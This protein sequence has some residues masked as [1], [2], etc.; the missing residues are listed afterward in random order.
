MAHLHRAASDSVE[1]LGRADDLAGREGLDDELAV[2]SL[3]HQPG[4]RLASA[5]Q[6]IE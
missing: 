1:R 3:R 5:E 4:K 2:S 6:S